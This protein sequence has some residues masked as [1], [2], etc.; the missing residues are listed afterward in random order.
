MKQHDNHVAWYYFRKSALEDKAKSNT[1]EAEMV[2]R[3]REG[4]PL[5]RVDTKRARQIARAEQS[6]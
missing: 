6:K 2:R 4:L 1:Y 5:S 3:Y